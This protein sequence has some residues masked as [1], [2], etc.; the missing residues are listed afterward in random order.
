MLPDTC[1]LKLIAWNLFTYTYFTKDATQKLITEYLLLAACYLRLFTWNL[2]HDTCYLI[3][4]TWYLLPGTCH[5]K[6][7]T[8]NLFPHNYFPMLAFR[9]M[10]HNIC[11]LILVSWYF[12]FSLH[13]FTCTFTWYKLKPNCTLILVYIMF[14]IIST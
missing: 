2:L 5:L 6:L 8:W 1:Y 14:Q 9:W 12:T 7:A 11:Y 13:L 4:A 3:L 10:L